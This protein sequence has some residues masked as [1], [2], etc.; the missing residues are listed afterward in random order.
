MRGEMNL[1]CLLAVA[2][3]AAIGPRAEDDVGVLPD[4]SSWNKLGR[5]ICLL[6][7]I[8]MSVRFNGRE[9]FVA[10]RAISGLHPSVRALSVVDL[11]VAA[12]VISLH[13]SLH[14]PATASF[15]LTML[16]FW[17]HYKSLAPHISVVFT[18]H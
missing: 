7:Q 5:D 8:V 12:S 3:K 11:M 10:A 2:A 13:P 15:T 16:P 6:Y 18:L 14:N 1:V 9:M 17:C 4:I